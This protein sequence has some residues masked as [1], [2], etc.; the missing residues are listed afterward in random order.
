[1]RRRVYYLVTG[2]LIVVLALSSGCAKND[3]DGE[4]ISGD[5][6]RRQKDVE[7]VAGKATI[8]YRVSAM[9][10]V[11]VKVNDEYAEGK[12]MDIYYPP[13]FAFDEYLP[14]VVVVNELAGLGA[15]DMGRFMEWCLLL[16]ASG[17][18]AVTYDP[19]YADKDTVLLFDHLE[20]NA[21]ELWMDRD[22][23]G[24]LCYCETCCSG[25]RI[26]EM[27]DHDF[28]DSIKAGV[29]LYGTMP[30]NEDL[31]PEA[32]IL[33]I[34]TGK[35]LADG[36]MRSIDEFK[37]AADLKG[38]SAEIYYHE[39]GYKYFDI[40]EQPQPMYLYG[41]HESFTADCDAILEVL[42][43]LREKLTVPP[44]TV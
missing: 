20:T 42:R 25:L 13:D 32:S 34:K 37:E 6:R 22:R 29:F 14:V 11:Q 5:A 23:M 12:L 18:I 39:T 24:L 16:A 17:M 41:V 44:L 30:W 26:M 15:K 43:F 38:V 33:M 19:V 9:N 1:M 21:E 2:I 7:Y 36:V 31:N 27:K 35:S 10:D 8:T 28:Y 4:L 40:T 3:Q